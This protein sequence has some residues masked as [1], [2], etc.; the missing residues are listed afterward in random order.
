M[1]KF[2]EVMSVWEKLPF[3]T[4]R[5]ATYVRDFI[6]RHDIELVIELGFFHGKSSACVAAILED[7][8]RG[9]LT[10][11]DT[12][13][14]YDRSPT[15]FDVLVKVGL[16]HRVTPIFAARSYTWELS[17]LIRQNP[18]PQ[19]DLCYLD[20]G[21]TWDATGFGF[22]LVHLLL[23]PGGWIIFDDLDWTI[24]AWLAR[25]P[26]PAGKFKTFS[27]DEKDSRGVRMVWELLVPTY[28]YTDRFE[29]PAFRWGIARKPL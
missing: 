25:Q 26:D 16:S 17:K 9:H 1:S 11:I 4:A 6:D 23:K 28:G 10:T 7:R 13:S 18:R 3:M 24:S 21:H 8:G 20:G 22:V 19:F 2:D 14:A 29:E 12:V 15:I 27:Q 5:Q